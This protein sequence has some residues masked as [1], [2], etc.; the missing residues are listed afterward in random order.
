MKS[1]G[2]SNKPITH[3]VQKVEISRVTWIGLFANLFLAALKFTGGFLGNS[4][5]VVADAV[6]SL[7][8]MT[9]DIAILVGV[10]Y[11]TKPADEMHPHG[12]QRLETMVTFGIGLTLVV[13]ATG[14]IW[15]AVVTLHGKGS[16]P[17][18]WI[19]LA[20]A[21]VSI[22]VKE[23]L[24]RWTY[25]TGR[26]IQ[27]MPLVA[28]AWHHRSDA[29]SSLPVAIA[30]AG[31]LI[32]P[33]WS[34]LDHVGAVMV[35]LFIYQAAFKIMYPAFQKLL[36]AGASAEDLRRIRQISQGVQGVRNAHK[37]RTRYVGSSSLGVDLHIEVEALMTV[38]DGHNISEE[39]QQ[40]LLANGPNIVDVV[41][42]L[43]PYEG[44]HAIT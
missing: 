32:A 6:H 24:Y 38:R 22:V 12:H 3:A 43:E 18:G 37:I 4:Q 16:T 10:K 34:F 41:V 33:T 21:L 27:S 28:N 7:S 13:A 36:D 14:L 26:R 2:S 39:V 40:R 31:G 8:D 23:I 29:L 25:A 9:T 20:V 5:A 44:E 30:V 42:H 19:A 11:W 15:N 17:P 35:S 1:F